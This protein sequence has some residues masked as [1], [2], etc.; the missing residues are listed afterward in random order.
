MA[1]HSSILAWRIPWTE[2]PG[3]YSPWSRK[4]SDTTEKLTHAHTHTQSMSETRGIS[5]NYHS[6]GSHIHCFLWAC[7][8]ICC[9]DEKNIKTRPHMRSTGKNSCYLS[10]NFRVRKNHKDHLIDFSQTLLLS[11]EERWWALTGTVHPLRPRM[12]TNQQLSALRPA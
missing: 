12:H 7:F 2:E 4:E 3:R 1:T 9:H 8:I 11:D 10:Q 6:F 5:R